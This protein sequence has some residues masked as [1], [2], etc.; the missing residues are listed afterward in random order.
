[1]SHAC[2][3]VLLPTQVVYPTTQPINIWQCYNTTSYDD[4]IQALATCHIRAVTLSWVQ[5]LMVK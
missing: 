1:M 3:L 5:V 2:M 4:I